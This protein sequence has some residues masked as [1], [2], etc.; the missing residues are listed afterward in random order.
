MGGYTRN[1]CVD[2]WY[3]LAVNRPNGS[4]VRS[5]VGPSL[6]WPRCEHNPCMCQ[7]LLE[8]LSTAVAR[9]G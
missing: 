7:L 8:W 4:P 5:Q 3:Q 2:G 1:D 6:N 9:P